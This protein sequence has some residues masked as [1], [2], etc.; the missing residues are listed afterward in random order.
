M[1]AKLSSLIKR[2]TWLD[3]LL[4]L[5]LLIFLLYLVV[6]SGSRFFQRPVPVEFL[7]GGDREAASVKQ[8]KIWVDISGS[9]VSPG[10]Y[11]LNAD[12]RIKDALV[13]AGGFS[14]AADREYI[15]REINLAAKIVDG[16]KIF[17]P[18]IVKV[19]GTAVKE[20][21]GA[22]QEAKINLNTASAELLMD[23]PGIGE[24]RAADI[25]KGRPYIK[26]D[27]LVTKKIISNA[28][29]EKI[30]DRVTVY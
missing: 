28:V 27:D 14:E 18:A 7:A 15:S 8:N 10:V 22:S 12:A 17:V 23:L 5:L 20:V 24:V 21:L 2:F 11:Q 1:N 6:I 29:F 9:V 16:Q 4:L 13:A 19:S 30:R 25:I 26:T 3:W